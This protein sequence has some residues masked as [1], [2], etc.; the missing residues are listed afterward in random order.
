VEHFGI[1]GMFLGTFLADALS[2]PI[3]PQFYMLTAI[4]AGEPQVPAMVAIC[5][6]SMI[7]GYVGYHLADR[8]ARVRLF[9]RHIEASR[10]KV[11]RLI[12]RH[13]Y[14]A[15]VIGSI[16][17]IPFSTL[18]YLSGLYR[19]PKRYLAVLILTRVPR[20][21]IFYVLIRAGFG[22]GD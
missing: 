20:L 11:D 1:A 13:G 19:V 7:A 22:V 10:A 4:S 21:L 3:P 16:T 17:P 18:C 14:W 5:A 12:E 8:L 6:A 15:I 2:F 9:A